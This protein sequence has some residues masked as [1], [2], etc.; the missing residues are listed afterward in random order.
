MSNDK[1]LQEKIGREAKA[2]Q[3]SLEQVKKDMTD[4]WSA[5]DIT[6]RQRDGMKQTNTTL[7]SKTSALGE[8]G[9]ISSLKNSRTYFNICAANK[10]QNIHHNVPQKLNCVK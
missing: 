9:M 6:E 7:E 5:L 1:T 4:I 10:F 2:L 3:S 8:D